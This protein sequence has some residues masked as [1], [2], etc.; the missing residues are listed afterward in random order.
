ME[1]GWTIVIRGLRQCHGELQKGGFQL[2]LRE[3]V[4]SGSCSPAACLSV[5]HDP[6]PCSRH[7]EVALLDSVAPA[8]L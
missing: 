6:V 8:T 5:Q 2:C 3:V 4:W 7:Q 1:A